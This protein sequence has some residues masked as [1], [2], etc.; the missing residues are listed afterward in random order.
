MANPD[1]GRDGASPL[2]KVLQTLIALLLL[3]AAVGVV[4]ASVMPGGGDCPIKRVPCWCWLAALF[5][6]LI[7][8][9]HAL[10]VF[11]VRAS[12]LLDRASRLSPFTSFAGSQES[13]S[14]QTNDEPVQRAPLSSGDALA[15]QYRPALISS[16]DREFDG[17]VLLLRY[18]LPALL[19]LLVTLAWLLL[20]QQTKTPLLGDDM[21]Y[22]AWIGLAGAYSYTLLQLGKR[23]FQ[24]DITSGVALWCAITLVLG[25]MLA[26]LLTR[27]GLESVAA[28]T[29][30]AAGDDAGKTVAAAKNSSAVDGL[31]LA[32]HFVA[33][34]SP[35]YIIETIFENVR[36]R[37]GYMSSANAVARGVPL[38]D[39]RGIMPEIAERLGEEGIADVAGLSLAD[40][41][42]LLRNTSFDRRQVVG[43]IDEAILIV[44]LPEHWQALEKFGIT[45]AIDLAWC[46]CQKNDEPTTPFPCANP[47]ERLAKGVNLEPCTLRDVSTRLFQDAQVGMV[48]ALYQAKPS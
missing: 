26:I 14:A 24:R 29:P 6:A 25:P 35:R 28:A 1:D 30:A 15:E 37:T 23:A 2:S 45:G 17:I 32:V 3:A 20:L 19:I 33:G 7:I 13:S 10:Y 31:L 46:S 4:W 41:V 11:M 40:P 16:V 12:Q 47:L 21:K 9:Q 42:R 5:P 43:W 34:F 44:T 39:V 48:W 18:G 36:K 8:V 38:T 22:A 27:L